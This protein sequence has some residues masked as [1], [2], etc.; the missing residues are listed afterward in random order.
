VFDF[1]LARVLRACADGPLGAPPVDTDRIDG[2]VVGTVFYMAPEQMI[3]ELVDDRTDQFAW[4][5]TAYELLSGRRP[6]RTDQLERHA[7]AWEI[8]QILSGRAAPELQGPAVPARA[9]ATI[10]RALAKNPAHR[11]AKMID[12]VDALMAPD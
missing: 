4:G 8:S 1:G 7:G 5:V 3:G 2:P 6:W 9:S 12:L 11:F 10:A